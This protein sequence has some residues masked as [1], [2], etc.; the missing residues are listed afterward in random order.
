MFFDAKAIWCMA[1]LSCAICFEMVRF[2]R[3]SSWERRLYAC[4]RSVNLSVAIQANGFHKSFRHALGTYNVQI[5][6]N[7]SL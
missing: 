5:D 7:L 3:F 1:I 6:V 4:A 2:H